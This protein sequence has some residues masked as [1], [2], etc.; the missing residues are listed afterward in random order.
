M[1]ASRLTPILLSALALSGLACADGVSGPSREACDL[2][3]PGLAP[4]ER[5][6]IHT[7][8]QAATVCLEDAR[9]GEYVAI[10]FLEAAR[11][12]GT[13]TRLTVR[14][15]GLVPP[16][17]GVASV[18][19]PAYMP[20]GGLHSPTGLDLSGELDARLRARERRELSDALA[21]LAGGESRG[22]RAVAA[23]PPPAA[24][25]VPAVGDVLRMNVSGSCSVQESREGRVV[26][27]T[28][29]AVVMSDLANPSPGFDDADLRA[30]GK[31]YDDLIEPTVTAGFG[32]PTD[33]D[34]NG[35]VLLFFT[36]GVNRLSPPGGGVAAGFFWSGDLFAP[37][38][39]ASA[40]EG[41]VLYLAVP[42]P[43]GTAGPALELETIARA[44]P[45]T[46]GHELQHLINS[47][48]R[49]HFNQ[50]SEFEE[51]WLNEGLSLLAE[52]ALFY[53]S[54]GFEPLADLG[55]D[56]VLSGGEAEA[57]FRAYA[58]PNVGR[59]QL[60]V[61]SPRF[62]S[63]IGEDGLATRG[64]TWA[65]LRYALDRRGG[66]ERAVVRA[67]VDT[68]EAGVDN[69]ELG[70]GVGDVVEWMGDWS[71]AVYADQTPVATD[72]TLRQPSWAY[73]ELVRALR[74][75]GSWP[76]E[77]LGLT[78]AGLALTLGPGNGAYLAFRGAAGSPLSV[79]MEPDGQLEEGRVR[80]TLL[81]VDGGIQR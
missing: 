58:L 76:I 56:E 47:S 55:V 19:A 38:E 51:T 69:L 13:S 42:D 66:D 27:V 37:S 33:I 52:E 16:N 6:T 22:G 45:G 63:P 25:A 57:A 79:R 53:A 8:G 43:G 5:L 75:D 46:I 39:C 20:Q 35:R 11:T 14:A 67:L 50:A 77:V 24:A 12:A 81:R 9:A 62:R 44:I 18:K 17:L 48:R 36:S 71:V 15:D 21:S 28:P 2:E 31:L 23:H 1:P 49:I 59:Y 60:F 10:P 65:F 7:R 68:R 80:L 70:L 78:D 3:I 54:S 40:N 32:L 29:R 26:A 41:E 30:F 61:Q 34:G 4:G 72:P 73:G 74:T 64:A